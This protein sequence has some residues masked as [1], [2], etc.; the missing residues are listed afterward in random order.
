MKQTWPNQRSY[1]IN[2]PWEKEGINAPVVRTATFVVAAV[3][4]S[5]AAKH[6][7]DYICDGVNDEVEINAA[8]AALPASGGKVMLSEGLFTIAA[9]ITLSDRVTLQGQG[10]STK[11]FLANGS[12]TDMI[13]IDAVASEHYAVRDLLLD[14]NKANQASGHGIS[15]SQND[16]GA[17]PWT[18]SNAWPLIDNVFIAYCKDDGLRVYGTSQ[19][20]PP[21]YHLKVV[22]TY[23]CDG[24]GFNIGSAD[25][26]LTDCITLNCGLGG[27]VVGVLGSAG[28]THMIDCKASGSGQITAASG[29]GFKIA[30]T[31]GVYV[32]CSAQDCKDAGFEIGNTDSQLFGCKADSNGLTTGRQP[33]FEVLAGGSRTLFSGC[34]ALDRNTGEAR[35]QSYGL[36]VAPGATHVI[37]TGGQ[38]FPQLHRA[39]AKRKQRHRCPQ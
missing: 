37:F 32:G 4:A 35:K 6:Q 38:F 1:D 30:S 23:K 22:I 31:R 13:D 27:Y 12:D 3:D 29:I 28:N 18:H 24:N 2:Q 14:G 33:G 36:T 11:I 25:M 21:A 15:L 19:Y 5:P 7:S 16:A 10:R 39:R 20:N 8:I 9:T 17:D 26:T 34:S